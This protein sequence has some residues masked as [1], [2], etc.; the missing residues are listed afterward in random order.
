MRE[1][2]K[3]HNSREREREAKPGKGKECQRVRNYEWTGSTLCLAVLSALL[4][5]LSR[6]CCSPTDKTGKSC[7]IFLLRPPGTPDDP[8]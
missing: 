4:R 2:E 1:R 3:S 6:G 7:S 8:N 5:A